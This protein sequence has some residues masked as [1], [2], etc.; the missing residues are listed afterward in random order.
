MEPRYLEYHGTTLESGDGTHWAQRNTGYAYS[1]FS[2]C[3][4]NDG[5]RQ[6]AAGD[7]GRI[8][9][10]EDGAQWI[11]QTSATANDLF[12]VF[13]TGDGKRIWAAGFGGTIVSYGVK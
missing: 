10:S 5:K 2:I 4:A 12:S 9:T 11:Q 8:E 6:W 13:A 3:G 1:L 7:R